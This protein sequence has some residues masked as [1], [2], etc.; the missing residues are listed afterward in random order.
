[1]L[2]LTQHSQLTEARVII[3]EWRQ[4]GNRWDGVTRSHSLVVR[5]GLSKVSAAVRLLECPLLALIE[6]KVHGHAVR[7]GLE[8]LAS[9]ASGADLAEE[10]I[11]NEEEASGD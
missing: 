6:A 10:A 4:Y 2:N 1:M 9:R 5:R 8:R 3:A 7:L 11:A